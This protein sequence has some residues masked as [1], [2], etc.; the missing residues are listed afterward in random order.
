MALDADVGVKAVAS[1]PM[2]LHWVSESGK[3]GQAGCL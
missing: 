2:W 3:A 1:R